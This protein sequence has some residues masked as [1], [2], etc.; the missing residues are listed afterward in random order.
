M[1]HQE[2]MKGKN[3]TFLSSEAP[4][5]EGRNKY[6]NDYRGKHSILKFNCVHLSQYDVRLPVTLYFCM[7]CKIVYLKISLKKK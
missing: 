7:D 3:L 5:K 2:Q 6:I 1:G 4:W